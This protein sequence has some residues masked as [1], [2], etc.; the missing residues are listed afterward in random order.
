MQDQG[1]GERGR[2]ALLVAEIAELAHLS[3]RAVYDFLA[4]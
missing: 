4:E 2:A 3:R 1:A